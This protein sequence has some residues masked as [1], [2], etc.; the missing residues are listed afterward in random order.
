MKAAKADVERAIR[1]MANRRMPCAEPQRRF[2]L[3]VLESSNDLIERLIDSY[4]FKVQDLAA[5]TQR[6]S[7]LRNDNEALRIE[8]DYFRNLLALINESSHAL[9]R[10]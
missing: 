2:V 7:D 1:I 9:L 5:E 10:R 3:E 6:S 8:N 4:V